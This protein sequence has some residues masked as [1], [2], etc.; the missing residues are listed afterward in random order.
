MLTTSTSGKPEEDEL[1]QKLD[2]LSFLETELTQRELDLATLT[3]ELQAVESRYMRIVGKRFAELD[4]INAK[5][6]DHVAGRFPDKAEVQDEA[7]VTRERAEASAK[8]ANIEDIPS[9]VE[10]F[11]STEELKEL[12][13]K[14][15]K[16][17]HPD[18]AMDDT[19]RGYR[20]KVM[21]EVNKAYSEG[22]VEKL[23]QILRE[24]D[25]S[26]EA[27]EGEDVGSRLIRT[28]RMI[29]RIRDRIT[30]I[31]RE[32]TELMTSDIYELK[33]KVDA[34]FDEG[35]DF[36]MDLATRLDEEIERAQ[37]SFDGRHPQ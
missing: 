14:I 19:D 28:I 3:A 18:L 37:N 10:A 16:K 15:S 24:W 35:R 5:I 9:A 26:P 31:E 30:A 4:L 21:V 2:E 32:M 23:N 1:K 11:Q 17:V 25:T 22:D 33:E 7:R 12:Y 36:I 34:A 29:A 8:A 6:A 13:R 27:I 20:N